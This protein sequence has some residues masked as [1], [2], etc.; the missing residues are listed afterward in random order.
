MLK[1]NVHPMERAGRVVLGLI[2][3][4]CFFAF[5]DVA[6]RWAFLIGVVPLLTGLMGS[7][8][9]YSILGISTCPMK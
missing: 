2:L 3:I 8:P 7:C 9:L 1:K 6:Y 5:P 4:A